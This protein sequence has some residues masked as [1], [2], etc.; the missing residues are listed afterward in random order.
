MPALH[1]NNTAVSIQL[2]FDI[3]D[4]NGTEILNNFFTVA[5]HLFEN[6]FNEIKP[7]F[8]ALDENGNVDEGY[9]YENA[10]PIKDNKVI[11]A[12]H[13]I[14]KNEWKN[15]IQNEE[16]YGGPFNKMDFEGCMEGDSPYYGPVYMSSDLS[17][18]AIIFESS[19]DLNDVEPL[20]KE[21]INNDSSNL[22]DMIEVVDWSGKYS[23]INKP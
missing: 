6:V 9:Y 17:T 19:Y 2:N 7:Q 20:C 22:I 5:K 3:D 12:I 14:I 18:V 23:F 11:P 13:S 1:Q 8:L 4:E 15:I 21:A 16:E 10:L